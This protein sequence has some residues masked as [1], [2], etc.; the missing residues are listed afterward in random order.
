LVIYKKEVRGVWENPVMVMFLVRNR[1]D[2][3]KADEIGGAF[4]AHGGRRSAFK[5][6]IGTS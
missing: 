2:Q 1:S 4:S 5:I 6:L 3:S